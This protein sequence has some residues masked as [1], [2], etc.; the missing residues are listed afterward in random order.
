MNVSIKTVE[1]H[2][3]RVMRKMQADSLAQLVHQSILMQVNARQ[4]HFELPE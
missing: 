4:C 3:A 1:V 2:R